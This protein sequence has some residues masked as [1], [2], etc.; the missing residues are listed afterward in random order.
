MGIAPTEQHIAA[1]AEGLSSGTVLVASTMGK[2]QQVLL[3]GRHRLVADEPVAAGGTDAGPG[4]Y[5]LL[6]MALGACTS[7]T[8]EMYASQKKWP[9]ERVEVRLSHRRL[10]SKDCAECADQPAAMIDRI[11]K[12]IALFGPLDEAQ[13]GRLMDIADKC[14]VHRTLTGTIVIASTLQPAPPPP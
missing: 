10:H 8:L 3:D 5:E 2:F 14:P 1:L 7:M 6:L 11:E 4:P 9:L 12:S 13:R